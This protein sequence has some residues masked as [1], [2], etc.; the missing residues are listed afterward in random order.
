MTPDFTVVVPTYQ[1][2]AR[3][4]KCLDALERQTLSRSQFEIIIVDDGDSPVTATAVA[5]FARQLSQQRGLLDI[6][7]LPQPIRRGAAAARN[8]GWQAARGRFIAFTDDDCLPQPDW[9]ANALVDFEQGAQCLTG[10][11]RLLPA[12]TS[13]PIS[14]D[15]LQLDTQELTSANCFFDIKL[16]DRL[17][18]F[19]EVTDGPDAEL[20]DRLIDQRIPVTYCPDAVVVHPVRASSRPARAP[21]PAYAHQQVPKTR[22]SAA[23]RL[24]H[25]VRFDRSSFLKY[26]VT[27]LGILAGLGGLLAG[28]PRLAMLGFSLWIVLSTLYVRHKLPVALQH[29]LTLKSFCQILIIPFLSVYRQLYGILKYRPMYG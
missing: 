7:Y 4:L 17:Q 25:P 5:L 13:H 24:R 20:L 16:F 28:W 21:E 18:G 6:R 14:P 27:I 2:P 22:S 11:I 1:Q 9:L 15:L 3:L 29:R 8:R 10:Q 12:P 19:S 26:C 23:Q